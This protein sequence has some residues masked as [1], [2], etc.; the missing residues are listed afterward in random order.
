MISELNSI[1]EKFQDEI[2]NSTL[3]LS[4]KVDY[5]NAPPI[6]EPDDTHLK[7]SLLMGESLP[8]ELGPNG[9]DVHT[10]ILS[11]QLFGP[12]NQG[13]KSLLAVAQKIRE[14]FNRASTLAG[15]SFQVV[16]VQPQ[17]DDGEFYEVLVSIPFRF[18]EVIN[19]V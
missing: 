1:I 14:A 17:G 10:G 13:L 3:N 8:I 15:V 5:P 16:S 7:V 19:N 18:F 11:V 6:A 12:I 9:T 4:G 2:E